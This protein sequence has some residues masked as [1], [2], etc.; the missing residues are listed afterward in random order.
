MSIVVHVLHAVCGVHRRVDVGMHSGP[1]QYVYKY[2][3]DAEY[4]HQYND[5]D[6]AAVVV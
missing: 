3:E 6:A 5:L 2:E 1:A 4:K